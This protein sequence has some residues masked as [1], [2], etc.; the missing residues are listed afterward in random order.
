M[1]SARP[2]ESGRK[3]WTP[4]LFSKGQKSELGIIN[5]MYTLNP[6]MRTDPPGPDP[7][8]HEHIAKVGR[9]LQ[10]HPSLTPS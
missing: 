10:V 6:N 1:N 8:W 7:E 5:A 3:K 4:R 9:A 2:C